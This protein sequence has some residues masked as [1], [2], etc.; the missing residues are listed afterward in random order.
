LAG[1][2]QARLERVVQEE[3]ERGRLIERQEQQRASTGKKP[4]GR[5]AKTTGSEQEHLL[6]Q[7]HRVLEGVEYLF[8][9]LHQL[10]EIVALSQESSPS[11]CSRRWTRHGTSKRV[12]C[13]RDGA[14]QCEPVARLRIGTALSVLIWPCIAPSRRV[15]WPCWRSGTIIGWLLVGCIKAVVPCN[16]VARSKRPMTGWSL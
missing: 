15:C 9:Q 16:A 14:W 2:V 7:L 5:P 6:S 12:A 11:N 13:S 8:A 1:Q 4:V 3:E 10:L